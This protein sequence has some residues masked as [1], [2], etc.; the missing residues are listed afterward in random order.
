MSISVGIFDE[1]KIA[2]EGISSLL[3]GI[4]DIEVVIKVTHRQGLNEK[5]RYTVVNVL[6]MNVHEITVQMFNLVS[7]LSINY[8][9]VKVLIISVHNHEDFV[10]KIIKAGAKGFLAK[11]TERNELI[12]AIYTLRN[13]YDYLV[14]Q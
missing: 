2:Q 4:D 14:N 5:L 8:P 7:Q 13:G 6:L 10:L 1:H 11:D 3:S 9:K 12:E